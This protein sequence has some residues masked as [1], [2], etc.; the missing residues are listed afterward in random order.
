MSKKNYDLCVMAANHITNIGRSL[1]P[2]FD[3][4]KIYLFE[5]TVSVYLETFCP[6]R[7]PVFLS[8]YIFT[9][10]ITHLTTSTSFDL[11]NF[12]LTG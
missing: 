5:N 3:H 7:S 2:L 11:T 12:A 1:P 9:A 10:G 6:R 8:Y 4:I